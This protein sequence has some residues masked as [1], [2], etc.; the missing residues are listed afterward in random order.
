MNLIKSLQISSVL[1]SGVFVASAAT[2]STVS[3]NFDLSD[4]FVT[5]GLAPVSVSNGFLDVTFSGGQQ[6]QMFD[7]PSYNTNPSAYL[8]VNGPGFIGNISGTEA[9]STGDMGLIDFNVPVSE[10]SFFGANRAM[11]AAT[12]LRVLGVDGTLLDTILITQ[13]SNQLGDGAVPTMISSEALGALIG[14]IEVDLPGPA[15]M[16][17]YVFAL[18]TFSATASTPE[19]STTLGIMA[20]G[21]LSASLVAKKKGKP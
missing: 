20:F 3:T 15:G 16:P 2:A 13:T 5:G 12:T 18:D 8:F 17:P 14:S 9:V 21:L 19:S 4:G 10:V 6:Q 7:G 1:A 11:G